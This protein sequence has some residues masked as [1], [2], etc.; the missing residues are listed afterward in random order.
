MVTDT[1]RTCATCGQTLPLDGQFRRRAA[2]YTTRSGETKVYYA[3]SC[4]R[5][6]NAAQRAYQRKERPPKYHRMP[7]F[8]ARGDAWC[9]HCQHYLPV[10][11]FKP[12]PS[13]PGALWAYCRECT[14]IKDRRRYATAYLDDAKWA[15]ECA[16]HTAAKRARRAKE[17]AE[18]R[19][20]VFKALDTLRHKG[21][22]Y[23]D[24][25]E[26]AGISLVTFSAWRRDPRRK[27]S[28]AAAARIGA[29]LTA[30][31]DLPRQPTIVRNR[32]LDPALRAVL[33]ERLAPVRP[34][35][36]PMRSR[37]REREAA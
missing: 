33:E 20:F 13:R 17:I 2:D 10:T 29:V 9:P 16:R 11:R 7:R 37:W 30:A 15:V 27:L 14:R 19:E 1:H 26:L 25:A 18:R 12:H 28:P 5:C 4:I 22:A 8:N 35:F 23:T 21:L 3:R 6:Q 31:L 32:R 36:I 34:T 24:I